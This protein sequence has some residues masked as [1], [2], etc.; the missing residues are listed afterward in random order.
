MEKLAQLWIAA[1][2]VFAHRKGFHSS[3]TYAIVRHSDRTLVGYYVRDHG[4][5]RP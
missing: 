5:V 1:A 3:E 2:R 4:M